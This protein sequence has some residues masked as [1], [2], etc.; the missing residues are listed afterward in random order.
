MASRLPKTS[1]KVE[2]VVT[3]RPSGG[4]GEKCDLSFSPEASRS[5]SYLIDNLIKEQG[6][7]VRAAKL[8]QNPLKAHRDTFDAKDQRLV[9]KDILRTDVD[10]LLGAL[11]FT[12]HSTFPDNKTAL[13]QRF[14]QTDIIDDKVGSGVVLFISTHNRDAHARS[15]FETA[16]EEIKD[17][18]RKSGERIP[19]QVNIIHNNRNYAVFYIPHATAC[20]LLKPAHFKKLEPVLVQPDAFRI[21]AE[22]GHGPEITIRPR[23]ANHSKVRLMSTTPHRASAPTPAQSDGDNVGEE[24]VN[25]KKRKYERHQFPATL[26]ELPKK[27]PVIIDKGPYAGLRIKPIL[28][29]QAGKGDAVLTH[30]VVSVP[31][32]KETL[33]DM[34]FHS[35]LE[36]E[37]KDI[38]LSK[39]RSTR[40]TTLSPQKTEELLTHI[41]RGPVEEK[42]PE[43]LR[44]TGGIYAGVS[45]IPV[46]KGKSYILT[47]PEERSVA[48][49]LMYAELDLDDDRVLHRQGTAITELDAK[50]AEH[51]KSKLPTTHSVSEPVNEGQ[52]AELKKAYQNR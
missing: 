3:Y 29:Y 20:E 15:Q 9:I 19:L 48:N 39:D 16:R 49:M 32:Q 18:A 6:E 11:H 52:V 38:Q 37:E 1:N 30:Y 24:I 36:L 25:K 8:T 33:G 40:F 41:G 26:I 27:D 13:R 10:R 28:T 5:F 50:Q 21:A 14:M 47:A 46:G 2:L 7:E 12:S 23:P 22:N 17:V 45:L 42:P 43:T 34:I 35:M 44:I 4:H 51:I 31:T